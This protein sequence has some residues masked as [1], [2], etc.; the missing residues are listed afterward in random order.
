M[1]RLSGEGSPYLVQHANNPVDWYPWGE[2]ALARAKKEDLPILLSIGYSACHW[3][4]VMEKESFESDAIAKLMNELFVCIKVDREE[5]PDL[6]QIYQL[7]VQMM[8]RN[9]GW[10]LTVF[11]TPDQ[12]PFFGGTYFPA[13]DRYGMPGFPKVLRAVADAYKEKRTDVVA[14][15]D[16]ITGAIAKVTDVEQKPGLKLGPHVFERAAHKLAQRFDDEH[17]GFGARPKFPNT[18]PLQVLLRRGA[19]DGDT[20]ALARAVLA[21][22][23]MRSGGIYDHLGGGFHRYSTD[24]RWLVPHFEKMLYDNALL[25]RLYVDAW[26]ATKAERFGDTAREIAAYVAREMTSPEGGFYATQAADSEGEEGKFFV[27]TPEELDEILDGDEAQVARAAFGIT[28]QGNFEESGATVLSIARDTNKDDSVLAR[29][30]KKMF[31]AREKRIKPFR[32]EKILTSWNGL[33]IGAHADA[34]AALDAPE[35]VTAAA[36]AFD[37]VSRVLVKDDRALRH[38]KDGIVKGPGF[39]D[40]YSFLSDAALDLYEATGDAAYV[41]VAQKLADAMLGHFWDDNDTA[42]FFTPDDGERLIHRAKDPYDHAIPSGASVA[43][44]VMSRLG[45]M[46][47]ERYATIATRGI[48]RLAGAALENPFGMSQTILLVDR[49]VRGTVDV[50][51]AGPKDSAPIRALARETLRAYLP[52]RVLAWQSGAPLLAEDKPT[53]DVPVAYVCRGRTCSMP[54]AAPEQLGSLLS[55]R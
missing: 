51:L 30:K 42:F 2:E 50:V 7:V 46:V 5:R 19:L 24:E 37:F 23:G 27:W 35:M 21:L 43:L 36:R 3:C 4:H 34:G 49:L 10:P 40:D 29:A 1:N 32:D 53:R 6:D 20:E 48:E 17:G 14:Q 8:G 47:D 15:A 11:L 25:M 22:D 54:V 26:R 12:K 33:M 44:G 39:L 13:E 41:D 28:R 9:G 31:E 38:V 18:M 45:T 16:E 55:A 52:N